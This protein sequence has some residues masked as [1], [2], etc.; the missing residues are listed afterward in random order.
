[1]G[2]TEQPLCFY[3]LTQLQL[4]HRIIHTSLQY[5][6]EVIFSNLTRHSYGKDIVIT[7]TQFQN[8][9]RCDYLLNGINLSDKMSIQA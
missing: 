8:K 2:Q 3:C 9:Y 5:R 4:F 1:M 6:F 7:F